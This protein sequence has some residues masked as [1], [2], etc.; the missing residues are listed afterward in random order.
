MKSGWGMRGSRYSHTVF[1][2]FI[3]S[4]LQQIFVFYLRLSAGEY[5]EWWRFDVIKVER[6]WVTGMGLLGLGW[7]SAAAEEASTDIVI[8]RIIRIIIISLC[9]VSGG[10]IPVTKLIT[11]CF[12][13]SNTVQCWKAAVLIQFIVDVGRKFGQVIL[14]LVRGY[15]ESFHRHLSG[16]SWPLTAQWPLHLLSESPGLEAASVTRG[17]VS[18]LLR[19]SRHI[20]RACGARVVISSDIIYHESHFTS[21]CVYLKLLTLR[22]WLWWPGWHSWA[23]HCLVSCWFQ[24]LLLVSALK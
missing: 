3:F 19:Q 9:A 5:T 17:P 24:V 23:R 13:I 22:R 2:H 21:P 7:R 12:W 11:R 1:L 8:I 16:V 14:D 10:F 20:T 15:F 18:S 6:M 4:I